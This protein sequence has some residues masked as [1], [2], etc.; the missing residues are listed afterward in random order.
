M[1]RRTPWFL[2]EDGET[3]VPLHIIQS[4]LSQEYSTDL[5]DAKLHFTKCT[6]DKVP[7]VLLVT[8]VYN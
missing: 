8:F 4:V 7:I 3:I 6:L 5:E 2:E 1:H